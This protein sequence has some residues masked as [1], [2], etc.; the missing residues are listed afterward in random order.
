[1]SLRI[2]LIHRARWGGAEQTLLDLIDGLPRDEYKVVAAAPPGRFSDRLAAKGIDVE[3]VHFPSWRKVRDALRNWLCLRAMGRLA[4]NLQTQLVIA[5]DIRTVPYAI[6]AARRS[7]CPCLAFIQDG[8]IQKRHVRAYRVHRADK[9]LCPS[10]RLLERVQL[11]GVE[12]E[13]SLLMPVGIDTERFQ[14]AAQSSPLRNE[15]E[16]EGGAILVGCVGSLSHLKGQDL[17][18]EAI[19]PVMEKDTRVH[20]ILI[21]SGRKEFIQ[22]LETRAQPLIES[23]R[24][25]FT[26]WQEDIPAVHEA[27]DIVVVSSRAESF[28]RVAAEAMAMGKPVI[29][30]KTGAV[31]ELFDH[32]RCGLSVP[33]EDPLALRKALVR[34]LGDPDLRQRL[35]RAGLER[36]Q[37]SFSLRESRKRFQK[38]VQSLCEASG[39]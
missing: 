8:T 9:V 29:A 25:R 39:E 6:E 19:L 7:H 13:R 18:L 33:V 5:G 38:I 30:S 17:L 4:S 26:G 3:L 37:Q 11:G 16:T 31:E 23:G 21:G 34:V 12:S 32:D 14:P 10:A 20:L 15:W 1:M 2:L 24:V 35:G 36:V 22:E 27:L 28:S